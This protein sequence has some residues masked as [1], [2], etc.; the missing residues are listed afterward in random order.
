MKFN[1]LLAL[2]TVY[3]AATFPAFAA[4]FTL[5]FEKEWDFGTEINGYYNGG[6]A[7]DGTTGPYLGVS[8]V[9]V[10]GLSNDAAGPYY[11]N[12]P[13]MLGVAYPFTAD[14]SD[15]SF[16]NVAVGV[17]R[18]LSF[19]YSSPDPVT[20][21]ILAYSGLNG[22]G[23][24]LGRLD[25]PANDNGNYETWTAITFQFNSDARSFDLTGAANVVALDNFSGDTVP[26][27]DAAGAPGALTLLIG[28]SGL[29]SDA[30]RRNQG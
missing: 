12:A 4:P 14:P 28:I 2:A 25:L 19:S 5:D 22:T 6:T 13:S 20:D 23:T 9:N 10:S 18:M 26:E 16:M 11:D 24:L 3:A 21:A 29:L 8:F 27:L 15:K 7:S 30:R 1:Q 17:M